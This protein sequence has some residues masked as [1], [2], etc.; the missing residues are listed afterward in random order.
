MEGKVVKIA[1]RV[2]YVNHDIDD[3]LR[4]KVI[5]FDILPLEPIKALGRHTSQRINSL[6]QNIVEKSRDKPDIIMSES[7]WEAMDSLRN[8]LFER[9][10]NNSDAKRE[11]PKA[12][13]VIK[14]LFRYFLEN[15]T[16]IPPEFLKIEPV[17]PIAVCDFI[18]GMTD[19]YAIKVFDQIFVPKA[20]KD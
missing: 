20:W 10:Y 2:A 14:K 18:A 5:S 12:I 4:G 13:I 11:D 1:D 19:R 8:F 3:A 15:P 6:V 17:L 9:V 7:Y 16:E